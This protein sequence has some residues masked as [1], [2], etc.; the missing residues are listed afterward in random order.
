M[1]QIKCDK[2]ILYDL[3]DEDLVVESP[4]LNL[5]INKKGELSFRIHESHPYFSNLKFL[6]S[7]IAVLRNN[8]TLFKG[9]IVELEQDINKTKNV[10]CESALAFLNDVIFEPFEFNGTPEEFFTNILEHYNSYASDNRKILKG[11]VTVTDPNDYI[12]R[13]SEEYLNCLEVIN[14]R[15]IDTLGGYLVERYEEDAIY[16]DWLEDFTDTSTQKVEAGSNLVDLLITNNASETY[17]A[18]LPLGAQDEETGDRLT[19]ESVNNGLKYIVNETALNN[20][21]FILAP[22]EKSTWDDV[23]VA[24]NLL[25]K[26]QNLLNNTAVMLKSTLELKAVDLNL[27]NAEI[28]AFFIYEYVQFLSVPHGIDATY[29]LNKMSIPLDDPANM[30]ITL[31]ETKSTLTGIQIEENKNVADRIGIIEKDYVTNE[32]VSN[33]VSTQI[34]ESTAISQTVEEIVLE[35]TKNFV[36]TGDFE[37]YQETVSTLFTQTAED[38]EFQ[39]NNITSEITTLNGDTQQQF[40]EIS[41]YIRFENGNIILGESGNE[42]TLKIENDRISFIQ[43][44]NEVAYLSNNKLVVTDANFLNSLQIGNFAFKPRA[45]GNLS[46]VYVGGAN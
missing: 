30:S 27:T 46:L 3:R 34:S 38:F 25:T 9:R 24:S 20:Y 28:E 4:Q 17:S 13:S 12:A 33:I 1:Y 36:E 19:I 44:N 21:G 8:K 15:L 26:A 11:N 39:F 16:L 37:S 23:T 31:G 43:N 5:E 6:K 22:V 18:V 40:Q 7:D 45:N 14:T 41:K 42:I 35:A 29:L 32:S 10:Y 2:Y